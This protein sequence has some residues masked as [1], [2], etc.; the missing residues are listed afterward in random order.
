[1]L[2]A[3]R[4]RTRRTTGEVCPCRCKMSRNRAVGAGRGDQDGD[5][6]ATATAIAPF[7][8]PI[9]AEFGYSGV[10]QGRMGRPY[11]KCR[12]KNGRNF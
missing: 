12:I 10:N 5:F 9:G 8:L 2:T 1:M 7:R 3:E 4:I 6:A 11:G